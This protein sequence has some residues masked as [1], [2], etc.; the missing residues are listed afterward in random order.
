MILYGVVNASIGYRF[1][2]TWEVKVFARNL[3]DKG[4]VTAL[5]VQ[6]GNSGLILGQAG[7]PRAFG[8]NVRAR[9]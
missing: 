2:E 5:T 7:D 9:F 4:Y 8:V 1:A 6:S 3:F